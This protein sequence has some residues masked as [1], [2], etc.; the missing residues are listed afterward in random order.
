MDKDFF[1]KLTSSLE[2]ERFDAWYQVYYLLGAEGVNII[3]QVCRG[4]D[5]VLKL[6]LARFC[7]EIQEERAVEIIIELMA[8]PAAQ[9]FEVSVR[10]FEKNR[11]SDKHQYLIPLLGS[12]QQASTFYAIQRLA[13]TGLTEAVPYLLKLLSK[14]IYAEKVIATLRYYRDRRILPV[15]IPYLQDSREHFRYHAILIYGSHY[16]LDPF[17]TRSKLYTALRD[18]NE[19]MRRVAIWCLRRNSKRRDKKYL[20]VLSTADPEPAVRYEA[21]AALANFPSMSLVKHLLHIILHETDTM[22]LLKTEAILLALPQKILIKS[23]YQLLHH[24]DQRVRSKTMILLSQYE[25]TSEKLVFLLERELQNIQQFK[26]IFPLLQALGNLYSPA[27][28]HILEKYLSKDPLTAFVALGAILKIAKADYYETCCQYLADANMAIV[29]KQNIL[30]FLYK[31]ETTQWLTATMQEVLLT[32]LHHHNLNLRYLS[33]ELLVKSKNHQI[34]LKLFDYLF[35]DN[36]EEFFQEEWDH[37]FKFFSENLKVIFDYFQITSHQSV[38]RA[39]FLQFVLK[40]CQTQ[41]RFNSHTQ[42]LI[43]GLLQIEKMYLHASFWEI[44]QLLYQQQ[45]LKL[46]WVLS[47]MLNKATAAD[48]LATLVQ[49]FLPSWQ[50][51]KLSFEFVKPYLDHSSSEIKKWMLQLMA[52]HG[53]H[54]CL[55]YVTRHYFEISDLPNKQLLRKKLQQRM[56]CAL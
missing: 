53:D 37:L 49:Q 13:S 21:I 28:I 30:K 7:A 32:L 9:V 46:E 22:V 18:A 8:D 40:Y 45:V 29:L 42:D 20:L 6:Y 17:Y 25:K 54:T 34:Y 3:K 23:F 12:D 41:H 2:D 4:S 19:R 1:K 11:F 10:C 31:Q 51:I 56:E 50:G 55:A 24:Q 26:D 48:A 39:R 38:T 47:S 27:A 5:L 36:R 33:F 35:T 43:V 52:S 16:D 15:I 14:E 44:M